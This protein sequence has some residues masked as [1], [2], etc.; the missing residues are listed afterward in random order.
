MAK[1]KNEEVPEAPQE[2][3]TQEKK[4]AEAK[5]LFAIQTV[6]KPVNEN[7]RNGHGEEKMS[8]SG[9]D[10]DLKIEVNAEI[11]DV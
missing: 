9:E 3:Q 6:N 1:K 4:P 11:Y 7:N 2:E 8:D 5:P 10:S